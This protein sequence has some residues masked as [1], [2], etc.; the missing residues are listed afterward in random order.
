MI[1]ISGNNPILS[2][3]SITAS[4]KPSNKIHSSFGKDKVINQ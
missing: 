1:N 4:Q 3:S 2:Q